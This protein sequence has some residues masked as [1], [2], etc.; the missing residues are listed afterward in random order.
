MLPAPVGTCAGARQAQT[1]CS[2]II[3]LGTVPHQYVLACLTLRQSLF[4]V[5]SPRC[6][7]GEG[8]RKV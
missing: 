6:V 8:V 1:T 3:P 7:E 2:H 4:L 5:P